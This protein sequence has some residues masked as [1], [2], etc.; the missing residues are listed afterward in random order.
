MKSRPQDIVLGRSTLVQHGVQPQ[1][2]CLFVLA[3]VAVSLLVNQKGASAADVASAVRAHLAAGEFA[4]AVRLAE[5]VDNA[6]LRDRLL[7]E[8]AA[9]QNAVGAGAAANQTIGQ[10]ADDRARAGAVGDILAQRIAPRDPVLAQIGGGG[11]GGGG[12]GG[13][14]GTTADFQPVIDLMKATIEPESWDD[15]PTRFLAIE[16]CQGRW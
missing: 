12:A 5:A 1:M 7:R 13:G 2:R 3:M 10:I 8:I 15:R 4:P 14:E 9:A 6:A 11:L 16:S